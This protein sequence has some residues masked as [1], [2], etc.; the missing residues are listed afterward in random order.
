MNPLNIPCIAL[1][2]S[3]P[4]A[5]VIPAAQLAE[6]FSATTVLADAHAQVKA[7][8]RHARECLARAEE[9]ALQIRTLARDQGIA[10][11]VSERQTMRQTLIEETLDWHVAETAL[12]ATLA[13]HLD[14][15]LRDLVA[16]VLQEF[17]GEQ[18]G[19]DLMIRRVQQRLPTFLA[20]GALTVRVALDYEQQ[21][22]HSLADHPQVQVLGCASLATAQALL[23]TRLF[24]LRIDLDAHLQSLLSRLR[25]AP[26][27]PP[28]DDYQDRLRQHQTVPS[29]S[30]LS[31]STTPWRHTSLSTAICP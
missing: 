22:R 12:E 17:I 1:P 25:Q 6:Y 5:M 21:V 26:Y 23:E 3:A 13:Q 2:G 19:V 30:K 18:D 15:R 16:Q 10:E 31:T 11:A 24:T 8:Q 28:A 7:L 9:E 14:T 20:Q 29:E 4:H 27:E